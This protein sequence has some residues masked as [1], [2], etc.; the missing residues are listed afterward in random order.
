MT[1]A[2]IQAVAREAGV[3][4]ST[5]SRTFAKPDLVLP[6]TRERVMAAARKLDYHISR[7][8]AALKSGQSFRVALL[9][10]ESIATWFNATVYAGLSSVLQPAGYDI[11]VFPMANTDD[12]RAFFETLPVRRNADAVI[13]SSFNID[14]AE[15]GQLKR[16]G[17]PIVG[18]N[19]PSPD[20][21]DAGVSIDDRAAERTAVEHLVALGHRRIAFVGYGESTDLQDLRF[22][23]SARLRGRWMRALHTAMT[24]WIWSRWS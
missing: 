9:T 19:I 6:E 12:R 15:V 13:V 24:G 14:P 5:V 8:A 4:P 2:S 22:S 7:S 23:A 10:S 18:V 21:F 20:G 3:S 11:A 17:V 16:M 1:K